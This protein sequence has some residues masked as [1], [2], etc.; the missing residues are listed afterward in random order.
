[1]QWYKDVARSIDYLETRKDIDAGKLGY[2]GS[3]WGGTMGFIIP[4][5]ESRFKAS[6]LIVPGLYLQKT[7][8][9]VDQINFISRVSIPTLMLSGRYDFFM[10]IVDVQTAFELLGTPE[11]DKRQVLYDTGHDI[12]R[13]E[14]IRETLDWFDRYLGQ[15][16]P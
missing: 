3:S 1:M 8:P 4:A 12:P 13:R 11:P 10:P 6:V 2:V 16:S 9:E 5:I 7:L 15:A 14:L